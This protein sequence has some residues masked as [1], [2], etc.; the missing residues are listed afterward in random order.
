[1]PSRRYQPLRSNGQATATLV[2][3]IEYFRVLIYLD[4][5]PSTKHLP[6]VSKRYECS[7]FPPDGSYN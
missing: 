3:T 7:H 5:D 4:N 2:P 6:V 1:M